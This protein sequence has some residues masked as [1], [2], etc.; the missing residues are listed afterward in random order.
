[1]IAPQERQDANAIDYMV[2]RS[3]A[4]LLTD[5]RQWRK[6]LH[7]IQF[8]LD[9]ASS[10][11]ALEGPRL[12]ELLLLFNLWNSGYSLCSGLLDRIAVPQ[13]W[14]HRFEVVNSDN[15]RGSIDWPLTFEQRQKGH[16]AY[17]VRSLERGVAEKEVF[18][19]LAVLEEFVAHCTVITKAALN[20]IADH[21]VPPH[22]EAMIREIEQACSKVED[23]MSKTFGAQCANA[24]VV[25]DKATAALNRLLPEDLSPEAIL[26]AYQRAVQI[27]IPKSTLLAG[28][29]K[30]LNRWRERYVACEV[31]LT[32]GNIFNYTRGG[33]VADLYEL[34][35]FFEL[36]SAIRRAGFENVAQMCFIKRG[37]GEPQF[38]IGDVRYAY[39][40]YRTS[41]LKDV[42]GDELMISGAMPGVFV[43]WFIRNMSDFRQSICM[44]AKYAN[45]ESR[46]V[47]KV[48]GYMQNFGIY[49]GV[50]IT[51]DRV[52]QET[53]GGKILAPGL[54]RIDCPLGGQFWIIS[55]P[56]SLDDEP[57]N[58]R[59]LDTFVSLALKGMAS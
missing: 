15:I 57:N 27:R 41:L 30:E 40:D 17:V 33:T 45:W 12:P 43:E 39:F 22:M 26:A 48:M 50:L 44:D 51:R 14:L 21:I 8:G 2:R 29:S 16:D 46:E 3:L 23:F 49:N 1:M 58:A 9:W 47:L 13:A 28:T 20:S 53:V 25:R 6:E 5:L 35:C 32:S 11:N 56:P 54:F 10:A 36:T 19:I 37:Q 52:R 38:R 42:E 18:F 55:L 34:W 59:A 7:S 31:R 24:K 4:L